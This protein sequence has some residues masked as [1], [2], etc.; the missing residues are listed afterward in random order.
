[1][2]YNTI[3]LLIFYIKKYRKATQLMQFDEI[4]LS[5]IE[6]F[7]LYFSCIGIISIIFYIHIFTYF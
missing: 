1:M 2:A 5:V 4:Q 7:F 6:I 3:I